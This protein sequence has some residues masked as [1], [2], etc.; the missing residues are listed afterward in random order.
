MSRWFV[1]IVRL[2]RATARLGVGTFSGV[3]RRSWPWRGLGERTVATVERLQVRRR[4]TDPSPLG[5][6]YRAGGN[7]LLYQDLPLTDTDRVLDAG[8]F[9]GEWTAGILVRYGCYCDLFEP[10]PEFM[11]LCSA[12]LNRNPRVNLYPAALGGRERILRF[13]L[14]GSGTSAFTEQK[15]VF[16]FDAPVVAINAYLDRLRH[17]GLSPDIPGALGCLK[18]NIEGGEYEVLETLL[19][20]GVV[21]RFRCLLI[22]FHRQP[23]GYAIRYQRITRDL[24]R[25]HSRVWGFPYVWERWD[26]R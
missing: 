15:E 5:D 12:L 13:T 21:D 22:Q 20:S 10:A 23:E 3:N 7:A 24:A 1:R 8:G 17:Q 19:N 16:G 6:F 14:A 4:L 26:L 9:H 18:L 11:N 2:V 25:T